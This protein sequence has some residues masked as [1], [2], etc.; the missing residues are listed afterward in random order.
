MYL[1]IYR[2]LETI[3]DDSAWACFQG[4]KSGQEDLAPFE[5][6]DQLWNILIWVALLGEK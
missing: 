5:T 6:W 1:T 4:R 3:A 2:L